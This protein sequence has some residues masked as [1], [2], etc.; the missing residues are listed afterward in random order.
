MLIPHVGPHHWVAISGKDS[1]NKSIEDK[2]MRPI[3]IIF[4]LED[5]RAQTPYVHVRLPRERDF[6]YGGGDNAVNFYLESDGKFL[7]KIVVG[8]NETSTEDAF[9]RA[10]EPVH[11]IL[12]LWS[13]QYKRPFGIRIIE[14]QDKKHSASWTIPTFCPTPVQLEL[15]KVSFTGMDPMGSLFAIFR[16]AMNATSYFYRFLS[17]YK[18]IEARYPPRG[19]FKWV[20]DELRNKGLSLQTP[21]R[22]VTKELIG[23]AYVA[24]YHQ[25]YLNR[26]YEW[27]KNQ[28]NDFRVL[29]AHPFRKDS[30][31]ANMDSPVVQTFVSALANL[32]ERM[33][34]QILEDELQLA[35]KIDETGIA[36]Q[37]LERMHK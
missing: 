30:R 11:S 28:F 32:A 2:S 36:K 21:K 8:L 37:L 15:L 14:I 5:N 13:F 24:Q 34:V 27:C 35:V 10:S 12:S 3:A 26:K 25:C 4:F 6:H 20:R 23:G 22:I 31:F 17:Y 1:T 16:E 18:I 9:R 33:A 7:E 19:P 29:I